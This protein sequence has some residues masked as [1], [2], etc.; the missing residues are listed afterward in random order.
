LYCKFIQAFEHLKCFVSEC[1]ESAIKQ[2]PYS[3][4]ETD[5]QPSHCEDQV[6]APFSFVAVKSEIVVSNISIVIV[7]IN[8][9]IT[10]LK[11]HY[12][13]L[14]PCLN[15]QKFKNTGK[16]EDKF[17]GYLLRLSPCPRVSWLVN[18]GVI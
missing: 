4:G 7:I 14:E 11:T 10:T 1:N 6:P 13:V 16:V 5:S 18:S 17:V 12:F 2:E 9:L 15:D 3:D 8:P